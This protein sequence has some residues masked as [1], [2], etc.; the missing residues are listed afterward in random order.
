[1]R[2][3]LISTLDP[4]QKGTRPL[5]TPLGL[6]YLAGTLLTKGHD[7]RIFQREVEYIHSKFC[8][9]RVNIKML[10]MAREF[11]PELIGLTATSGTIMDFLHSAALLRK[12][13]P[14]A[15]IVGGGS[16]P[17]ALPEQTLLQSPS[18]DAVVLGDGEDAI[19]ELCAGLPPS[20]ITG[21]VCR[22]QAGPFRT[23][24][25][26]YDRNLDVLP[27]PARH[28]LDM[29]FH[30]SLSAAVIPNL[31]LRT[32]TIVS[33]RGCPFACAYCAE[34]RSKTGMRWHSPDYVIGEIEHILSRYRVEALYFIDSMF[35]YNRK[36]T[37]EL[38][39]LLINSGLN[40]KLVWS[41]QARANSMDADLLRLMKEAGC[42]QIEYGFE[43]GSQKILDR[44][45]KASTVEAAI[46]AAALTKECGIRLFANMMFGYPG[47][48]EDDFDLSVEFIRT[49]KPHAIGAYALEAFPG[50]AL[51]DELV[52]SGKLPLHY[53]LPGCDWSDVDIQRHI[54]HYNVSAMPQDVA[55]HKLSSFRHR[56]VGPLTTADTLKNMP[57]Q[58]L[59]STMVKMPAAIISQPLRTVRV[60]A[61]MLKRA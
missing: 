60:A 44:M 32:T 2:C 15:L 41:V 11:M 30:T 18:L 55:K 24:A 39:T 42:I 31:S 21:I 13:F 19:L 5:L 51:Y 4:L 1:M 50:T 26:S 58:H 3:L 17:S 54:R 28:L 20:Q 38:C 36:R 27:Y 6:A 52:S 29:N 48:T 10:S 8:L 33:A 59:L 56:V 23:P 35:E 40:K 25:R 49:I 9:E 47:E 53:S 45:G 22:T 16:H 37:E 7:V 46:K 14:S 57:R 43:S 12:L 34:S 61:R